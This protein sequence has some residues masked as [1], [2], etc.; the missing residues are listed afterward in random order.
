[1]A[2]PSGIFLILIW[3]AAAYVTLDSCS[4]RKASHT[5]GINYHIAAAQPLVNGHVFIR[6]SSASPYK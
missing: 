3:P 5:I 4:I 1:M 6:E 2:F